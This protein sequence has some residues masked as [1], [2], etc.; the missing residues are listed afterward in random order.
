MLDQ[1]KLTVLERQQNLSGSLGAQ[2]P[3]AIGS[4]RTILF[5]DVLT[6]GATLSEATRVLS[7][8]GV[9]VIAVCVLADVGHRFPES[10]NQA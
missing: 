2:L 7:Q 5:D 1:S 8:A 4:A 3:S 9:E 6:T 10:K